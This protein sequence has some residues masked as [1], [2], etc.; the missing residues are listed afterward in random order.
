[1]NY[2]PHSRRSAPAAACRDLPLAPPLVFS[3]LS[4]AQSTAASCNACAPG[5]S[6][7]RRT[8]WNI[9]ILNRCLSIKRV[10]PSPSLLAISF[11]ISLRS[12]SLFFSS[13]S[14]SPPSALSFSLSLSHTLVQ[15]HIHILSLH[16]RFSCGSA[17]AFCASCLVANARC[18]RVPA[19]PFR[20]PQ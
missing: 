2:G 9:L 11:N 5:T 13:P 16:T 4:S 10:R 3:P 14:P 7:N 17:A 8:T 19:R 15:S 6:G 1:M 18:S 20:S 12:L